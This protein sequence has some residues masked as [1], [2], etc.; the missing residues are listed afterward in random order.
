MCIYSGHGQLLC[1]VFLVEVEKKN[2]EWS[3]PRNSDNAFSL[4]ME[5]GFPDE[6]KHFLASASNFLAASLNTLR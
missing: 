1:S 5:K 3:V 2:D 6:R 4:L